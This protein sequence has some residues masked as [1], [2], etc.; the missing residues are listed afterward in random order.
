MVYLGNFSGFF[1]LHTIQQFINLLRTF[2][3]NVDVFMKSK[4]SVKLITIISAALLLSVII[5]IPL[6]AEFIFMKNGEIIEGS[7]VTDS[8]NSV[9]L[10][11]ADKKQIKIVRESRDVCHRAYFLHRRG[12]YEKSNAFPDGCVHSSNVDT[13]RMQRQQIGTKQRD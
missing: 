4:S 8:A 1:L 5:K 2:Y 12:S 13:Y 11:T 7:I 3:L 10:R 6:N 9:I